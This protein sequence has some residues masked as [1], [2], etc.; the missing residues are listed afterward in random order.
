M[1]C[2]VRVWALHVWKEFRKSPPLLT[3]AFHAASSST[4]NYSSLSNAVLPLRSHTAHKN[5]MFSNSVPL[6]VH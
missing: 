6:H 3:G 4:A 2:T 1:N 5:Q